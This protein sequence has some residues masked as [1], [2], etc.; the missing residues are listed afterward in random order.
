M[1]GEMFRPAGNRQGGSDAVIRFRQPF[2][3]KYTLTITTD[4]QA[5]S[6]PLQTKALIRW[7]LRVVEVDGY[8]QAEMELIT[9]ENRLLEANNPNL[10]E[11]AA[12]N[13]AFARMYSE[14][15][16][17]LDPRGRLL[18]VTNLPVIL[19]KWEQTKAEMRGIEKEV[20]ALQEV[21]RL[22]DETFA[23]P[24]K[25]RLAVEHNEFFQIYFHLIYGEPLPADGLRRTHRNLFNSADVHWQYAAE[26]VPALPTWAAHTDVT[27]TGTPAAAPDDEWVRQAYGAFGTLDLTQLR[28]RLTERGQ[29][30]F[31][32]ASGKLLAGTLV[33]EEIAHPDHVRGKMTYELKSDEALSKPADVNR[34][35]T[36][37]PY[38]RQ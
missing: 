10:K 7:A 14:I 37:T 36:P 24:E 21:I 38:Y 25:V 8:G 5:G 17:R 26:A 27:V 16:A 6:F 35:A 33:K 29:Y 3:E 19:G 9:V 12:L 15:Q 18:E 20:P 28:P 13:Q 32:P 22:N 11:I 30:R 23:S 2:S 34:Q 1:V 4:I 31:Q